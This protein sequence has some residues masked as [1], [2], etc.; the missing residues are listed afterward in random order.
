M[1]LWEYFYIR[2]AKGSGYLGAAPIFIPYVQNTIL[3]LS[4]PYI[5]STTI[6]HD[7]GY[8]LFTSV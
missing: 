8:N 3:N 2:T 4:N 5:I 6:L 1:E 7:I